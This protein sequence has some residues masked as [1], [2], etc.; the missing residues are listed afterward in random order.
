MSTVT[1]GY[2][3]FETIPGQTSFTFPNAMP[4]P[5]DFFH[6]GS[7]PFIG[8]IHLEG[9][10]IREF[11]HPGTKKKHKTGTTDTVVRRKQ[12]VTIKSVGESGTTEIELVQLSLRGSIHVQVGSSAQRWDVFVSVS[13][14]K[15]STGH[16]TVTQTSEHGGHFASQLTVWPLFRFERRSDGEERHLDMGAMKIADEK[17]KLVAAGNTLQG[18][19]VPW[20]DSHPATGNPVVIP[21][22]ANL[23]VG[24]T[25]SEQALLASHHFRAA[26]L[27]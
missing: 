25:G 26:V 4:I 23:A 6:K 19:E 2:D 20:Q 16:M 17:Q 5:A 7:A 14:S 24:G 27:Q 9:Y 1:A 3:L 12:D 22:L 11:T 13:P 10:P 15:A 8:V 18:S 21:D